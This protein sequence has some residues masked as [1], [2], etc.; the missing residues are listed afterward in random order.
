VLLCSHSKDKLSIC[1][2]KKLLILFHFL[3]RKISRNGSV[4]GL[5]CGVSE[6]STSTPSHFLS[7]CAYHHII[8]MIHSAPAPPAPDDGDM[9]AMMRMRMRNL[10]FCAERY[11][12][13]LV[14]NEH[15]S[16]SSP[17]TTTT[18]KRIWREK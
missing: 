4:V 18:L 16:S 15:M 3:G 2:G 10:T 13:L 17:H 8:I 9:I 7:V 11:S 1:G 5:V 6:A 12:V 14:E